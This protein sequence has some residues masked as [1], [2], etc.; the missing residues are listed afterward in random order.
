MF[1]PIETGPFKLVVLRP[2]DSIKVHPAI[3]IFETG[4]AYPTA[5]NT[6]FSAAHWPLSTETVRKLQRSIWA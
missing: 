3:P 6:Q 4:R 2:T 1:H 5:S